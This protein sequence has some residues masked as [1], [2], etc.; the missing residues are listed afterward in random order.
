MLEDFSELFYKTACN[1]HITALEF[2]IIDRVL[3]SRSDMTE[4]N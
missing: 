2:G 4:K 3:V 1:Y